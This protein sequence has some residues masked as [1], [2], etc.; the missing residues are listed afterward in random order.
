MKKTPKYGFN[1]PEGNDIVSTPGE[2]PVALNENA[3]MIEEKLAALE[4]A[5]PIVS[6]TEPPNQPVGALWFDT[7]GGPLDPSEGGE[8]VMIVGNVYVGPTPQEN[9]DLLWYDTSES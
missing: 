3:D 9:T 5:L 8:P 4:L 2:G 7:S 6:D 1:K